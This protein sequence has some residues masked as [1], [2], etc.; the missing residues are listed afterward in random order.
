VARKLTMT[1]QESGRRTKVDIGLVGEVRGVNPSVIEALDRSGFI[2]VIAPI[3]SGD[4]G[5]SYNINA[6]LVAGEIAKS[7][8]ASKLMLLTDVEGIRGADGQIIPTIDIDRANELIRSGVIAGGMIPKV[9]CCI[10]ALRGG[11]HKTHIVDGRVRHAVLLEIF[12][13]AGVG[14]E[15]VRAESRSNVARKRAAR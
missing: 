6:D 2:P 1:T 5:E 8:R 10:D 13:N 9:E 14:T 12:T 7:L 3:G 15:V 11:T 4:G